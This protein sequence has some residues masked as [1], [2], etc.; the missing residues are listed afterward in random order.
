M[1]KR[2]LSVVSVILA[3]FTIVPS[4]NAADDDIPQ[5]HDLVITQE[6]FNEILA[7]NVI[8]TVDEDSRA[9]NL[10]NLWA[11]AIE[12][13]RTN[14]LKIG[15]KTTGTSEVVKS[16]FKEL[17]IQRRASS[18]AAWSDYITYKDLYI[19]EFAYVLIKSVTVPTG[20]QYRV[21]CT[22]YAKKNFLSVQKIDNVSNVVQF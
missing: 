8:H 3:I 19:D 10:I 20:Y 18:S 22:H 5:W 12:K 13:G 17:I 9:S 15:G 1:K 2:V 6:E 21:T 4:V 16:G 7:N 11:I 14:E